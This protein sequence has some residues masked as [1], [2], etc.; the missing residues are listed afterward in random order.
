MRVSTSQLYQSGVSAMQNAQSDFSYTGLQL[1]TGKRILTPSDDP[2]GATQAAQFD[3]MIAATE[4]FQRNNDLATPRLQ[5][6]ESALIGVI[7]NLQRVRELVIAGNNSSQN[8][9]TRGYLASEIR[10]LRKDILALANTQDS[11]GEYLFSGTRSLTLPFVAGDQGQ[12]SYVGAEGAGAIREVAISST[13][14]VATGDTGAHVFMEI[15]ERSGLL[16][17]AVPAPGNSGDLDV[18]KVEAADL[19]EALRSA[20][21][22]FRIRFYDDGGTMRYQVLDPAGN[23]VRDSNSAFIG[24]PYVPDQPIE[25]VGR[26]I[27][28]TGPPTAP[29]D[30]D[31]IISRPVK[32]MSLFKTL[33]DIATALEK[34]ADDEASRAALSSA[35]SLALRNID[36]G[37]DRLNE[38]RASVGSRLQI[39]ETQS[40]LNEKQLLDMEST[41][42]DIRDLDY[43]EAISRFKLQDVV[44]QAAQQTYVQVTRLSLFDFL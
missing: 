26:R 17:E 39:L 33:D 3:S 13:R 19:D 6:E 34:P 27:T 15:P 40:D 28:L 16:T 14:R 9:E 8:Q 2:S 44:L 23:A 31:E 35:T 30:G 11:N 5:R 22:T 12:V 4:Q 18:V 29:A 24:G 36:S 43:A 21:E 37:L 41:L 20:G 32:Q 25:F 1:A 7:N 42:S 10:Q 38:V